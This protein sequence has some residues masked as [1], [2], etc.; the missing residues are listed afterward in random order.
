MKVLAVDDEPQILR[1]VRTSLAARGHEVTT[2]PNG[3]T[4]LE[5]E[6]GEG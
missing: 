2:A 6:R 5:M 1:A 3:E 4:A